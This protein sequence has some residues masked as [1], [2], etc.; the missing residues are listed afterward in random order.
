MTKP[1]LLFSFIGV[2]SIVFAFGFMIGTSFLTYIPFMEQLLMLSTDEYTIY[3]GL[4]FIKY[5][6]ANILPLLL[7]G[8]VHAIIPG[9]IIVLTAL[10]CIAILIAGSLIQSKILSQGVNES[11]AKITTPTNL[12][13][14]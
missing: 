10:F 7:F 12:F 3:Y 5:L 2:F 13:S 4:N 8:S 9:I 14:I 11:A 1:R 6:L